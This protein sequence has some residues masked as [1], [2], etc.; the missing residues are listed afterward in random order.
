M[1]H[2]TREYIGSLLAKF[3]DGTTTLAEEDTLSR[4]FQQEDVPSEWHDY[5]QLFFEIEKMRNE[6]NEK[7]AQPMAQEGTARRASLRRLRWAVAAAVAGVVAGAAILWQPLSQDD[8]QGMQ[9]PLA[10]QTATTQ[11]A[12]TLP[13]LR[14]EPPNQEALPDTAALLRQYRQPQQPTHRRRLRKPEPTMLDYDKAAV[15]LARMEQ[16]RDEAEEQIEQARQEILHARLVAAGYVAIQEEDGTI[17][18]TNDIKEYFAYE[19]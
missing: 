17:I 13:V 5:Q 7:A 18:Y 19:E 12:D 6:E 14:P 4:Y 3:M 11:D 16:E 10:A 9:Q 2:Y 15:L 8:P 1:R